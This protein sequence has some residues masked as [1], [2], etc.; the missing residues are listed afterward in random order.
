MDASRVIVIILGSG[1]LLFIFWWKWQR[2]SA[3]SAQMARDHD[4]IQLWHQQLFSHPAWSHL[5]RS[6]GSQGIVAVP[7]Q[8]APGQF[9]VRLL[10][11]GNAM[12]QRTGP[13]DP[14]ATWLNAYLD[15]PKRV[16]ASVELQ[17]GRVVVRDCG[18][19][20]WPN[21]AG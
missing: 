10:T 13:T 5:W 8:A 2:A 12:G 18:F 7:G 14:S 9:A 17:T 6:L 1:F 16:V 15:G 3:V 21:E 19:F 4:Q 11:M 20:E